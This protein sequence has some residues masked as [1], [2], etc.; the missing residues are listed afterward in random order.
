MGIDAEVGQAYHTVQL[1][2][3]EML[4]NNQRQKYC[5][6]SKFSHSRCTQH[7]SHCANNNNVYLQIFSSCLD[8]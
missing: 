8:D 7:F 4:K 1:S 2:T 3:K 6:V 5:N